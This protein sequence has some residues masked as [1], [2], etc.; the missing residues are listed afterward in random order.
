MTEIVFQSFYWH[1]ET[2]IYKRHHSQATTVFSFLI[3]VS[4]WCYRTLWNIEKS[5]IVIIYDWN[6][7]RYKRRINDYRSIR[8]GQWAL[9]TLGA[10]CGTAVL[11]ASEISVPQNIRQRLKQY[12]LAETASEACIKQNGTRTEVW[13]PQTATFA[14]VAVPQTAQNFWPTSA[15]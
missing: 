9:V 15:V 3:Y 13:D 2:H 11:T 10:V 12:L 6:C 4:E 7:Q 14:G 1:L 5:V 8:G